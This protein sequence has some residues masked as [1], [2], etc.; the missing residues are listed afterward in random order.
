MKLFCALVLGLSLTV[1][2]LA[3]SLTV[4]VTVSDEF[5]PLPGASVLQKGTTNGATTDLEG[6]AS[7]SGLKAG[8]VLEISFLGMTTKEVT[9][10]TKTDIKVTLQEDTQL[11]EETVV[12]GYGVQKKESLT[13]AISQIRSEDITNTKSVDA[14]LSLQGKVPGLQIRD[15]GGK[16]GQFGTELSLRGYGTPMIVVDGV[17]RSST[18][19]RKQ[20][21]G[22]VSSAKALETY[23]DMSVLQELNPEDIESVSVL[24]DA[25]AAIYGLGAANGVILI[26]TKKGKAQKPSVSFSASVRLTE[27]VTNHDVEDWGNYMRYD[28]AMARQVGMQPKYN[29]DELKAYET[30]KWA[31][32][33]ITPYNLPYH[34]GDEYV[35]FDW[36]DYTVKKVAVN[37]NYNFSLRGGTEKISYYLGV[38]YSDDSSILRT[39]N[40]A[41]NRINLS[42]NVTAAITDNLTLTYTMAMRNSNQNTLADPN[43]DWNIQYYILATQPWME[44]HPKGD[45]SHWSNTN[46]MMNAGA[47]FNDSGYAKND[48][49]VFNNTLD[50]KYNAPFLKGL[51]FQLS[52]AYDYNT[53]KSQTLM[54]K[55]DVYDYATNT[56]AGSV[57]TSNEY[58]ELWTN[59][60]RL[61]A[62]A[63]ANY[64]K[65]FGKHN[66]AATLA[67]EVTKNDRAQAQ[68][69]RKYGAT[70]Q[71]SFVT[72]DV[73]NM[74]IASTGENAG[75]RSD[76]ATAGY[77][78]RLS[79]NYAGKYLAEVMGRYDGT[80]VYQKGKRW[81][82]F[83]SYSLGWRISEEDFFKNNIKFINNLKFRWSDGFTGMTQGSPYAYLN[84]Y[85]SSGSWVFT[86]GATTPGFVNS[87][88]ANTILTWADVRMMDFGVDFGLWHGKLDGSID[89]FKRKT[90][91]IEA[92]PSVMVPDFYG[93]SLPSSNLNSRENEGLEMSLS[94]NGNIGEFSYRIGASLTYS[95]TRMTYIESELTK[96]YKSSMDYWKNNTL[97]RWSNARSASR[98][99][100]TGD[101]ITCLDDASNLSVLY[102]VSKK[103]GNT[104]M[105]PGQYLFVDRDGDGYITD[106]DK[107]FIWGDSNPPLQ[108]GLNM[109]GRYR[110]FDFSMVFSGASLKSKSFSL[111]SY[112][113][114]GY[115]YQLPKMY[116]R[117][118]YQ[119]VNYDDD[120]WDPNTEWK[121]GYW[122]VLGKVSQ[123]TAALP[124][125]GYSDSQPYNNVNATYLRLK[126]LELGYSISPKI[127]KQVGIKSTRVFFNGGNLFTLCNRNLRFIDPESVDNGRAGGTFQ[128]NRTY[129]FGVN[130]N[131]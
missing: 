33:G 75:T 38:G 74:G 111:T 15:T 121:E 5:G 2:A 58:S 19:V 24:K 50:L 71:E 64:N 120:P 11:L 4:K 8:D 124:F 128:I 130:L 83:P 43:I 42:G 6:L 45:D 25:S 59:N 119:M 35:H 60:T 61:Y 103:E 13:G 23:N 97:N 20:Q 27:P 112:A 18:M 66:I 29:D 51:T 129:N 39:D 7:I 26:T 65:Q 81:G 34:T 123:A 12:V 85:T 87:T 76:S 48:T 105:V 80:Y 1:S 30:G 22:Y 72:H 32:D 40:Y 117:D 127:L 106:M 14:L 54:L 104:T 110:N 118:S 93:V 37:Q 55:Y 17:V 3:Q 9:V 101:R 46:E 73:I 88:V 98:Y 86:D 90:T 109:S 126:S 68:L 84:G 115:L 108:F 57:K 56:Y 31:A 62:R 69:S 36:Y 107:F 82:F 92:K 10:G 122:P 99:E 89:W 131:F 21:T 79:Y 28:N 70:D 102:S 96:K 94:S 44:P 52:G 47:I 116:S 53:L 78:S 41:Y 113:G 100:W 125:V 114:F 91:G 63:Q 16:P 67:A 49:R 95:R 77:I